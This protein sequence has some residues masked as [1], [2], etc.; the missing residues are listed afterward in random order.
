LKNKGGAVAVNGN[1][2]LDME[3]PLI[4]ST[5]D[6]W[7]RATTRTIGLATD[8]APSQPQVVPVQRQILAPSAAA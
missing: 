7:S 3:N 4:N 2:E 1:G 8:A 6:E 5:P